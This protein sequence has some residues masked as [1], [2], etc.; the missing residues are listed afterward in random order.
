LLVDFPTINGEDIPPGRVLLP[1]RHRPDANGSQI[2]RTIHSH[3]V[4]DKRTGQVP[5]NTIISTCRV[6]RAWNPTDG[7]STGLG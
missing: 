6:I 7:P 3:F 4:L 5:R 1:T 2:R